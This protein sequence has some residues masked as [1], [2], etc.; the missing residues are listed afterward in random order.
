MTSWKSGDPL[1]S[2]VGKRVIAEKDGVTLSGT[3]SIADYTFVDDTQVPLYGI[4]LDDGSEEY[5]QEFSKWA[6]K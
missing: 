5:I 3:I 6:L 1:P 2:E 4:K